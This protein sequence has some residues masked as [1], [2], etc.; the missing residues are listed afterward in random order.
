MSRLGKL[1][2]PRVNDDQKMNVGDQKLNSGRPRDYW[3]LESLFL[4]PWKENALEDD[5]KCLRTPS[6]CIPVVL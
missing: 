5:H 3:I 6:F 4:L 2:C 1:A